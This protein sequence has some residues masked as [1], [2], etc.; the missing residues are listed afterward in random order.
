MDDRANG[1]YICKLFCIFLS[2]FF[3]LLYGTT[4]GEPWEWYGS[5]MGQPREWVLLVLKAGARD[6]G[7]VLAYPWL[8]MG[9][10]LA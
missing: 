4:M 6:Y 8:G 10:L 5:T 3:S 7:V 1:F 2:L 9:L